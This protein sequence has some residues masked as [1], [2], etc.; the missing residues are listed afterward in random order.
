[1]RKIFKS[2]LQSKKGASAHRER[3]RY[4]GISSCGT[5]ARFYWLVAEHSALSL[6]GSD[7]KDE[8]HVTSLAKQKGYDSNNVHGSTSN[9]KLKKKKNCLCINHSGCLPILQN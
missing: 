6:Y 1:M 3:I 4:R 7:A 2:C 9:S 8:D 5:R